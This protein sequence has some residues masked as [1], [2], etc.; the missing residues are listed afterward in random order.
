MTNFILTYLPFFISFLIGYF[1]ILTFSDSKKAVSFSEIIFMAGGL[2]LG[3]SAQITFFSF[4]IFEHLNRPFVVGI[5]LT[6]LITLIV[7][8]LWRRQWS[9]F[10]L[11]PGINFKFKNIW[12]YLIL[13]VFA[14]PLWNHG[15]FYAF[16][17]WDAWA[18]WNLKSKMLFMSESGWNVIFDPLLWRSS[19]HYPLLLPMMNNWGWV[20]LNNPDYHVPVMTAFIFGF[21]TVGLLLSSLLRITK[22]YYSILCVTLLLTSPMFVKLSLSQYADIIVAYYLLLGLICLLQ[23]KVDNSRIYALIGGVSLG[24]LSFTKGEGLIASVI[25]LSLAVFYL[26]WKNKP[27]W[28]IIF[29]LYGAALAASVVTII[30]TLFF[31]PKNQTFINGLFSK[32]DPITFFRIKA[33]FIFYC[34]EMVSSTW[35]GI[36]IVLIVG[37]IFS[38]GRCFNKNAIIFPAFLLGY[39]GIITAFFIVNT[40]FESSRILWWLQVTVHRLMYATLPAVVFWTFYSLWESP[41]QVN[42]PPEPPQK[43]KPSGGKPPKG[44]SKKSK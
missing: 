39:I 33:I 21:S 28:K 3:I 36:W 8:S 1:F 12:P 42:H 30:F 4:A 10:S 38:L 29:N 17:G 35:N 24:L 2:G 6:V 23:A 25:I 13:I 7:I 9:I 20:F 16:G 22:T 26:F 15:Q 41:I 19:P 43:I 14:Y 18:T 27:D 11:T 37:L 32:T 44:K 31:A 5:N 34:A 40:Y